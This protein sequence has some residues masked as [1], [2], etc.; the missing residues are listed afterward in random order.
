MISICHRAAQSR[1]RHQTWRL[2]SVIDLHLQSALGGA[3]HARE[4]GEAAVIGRLDSM[5]AE[6]S[7]LRAAIEPLNL[8]T[9]KE[10]A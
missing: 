9:E 1:L 5:I 6:L 10:I 4:N 3:S 2:L 8:Q 7:A